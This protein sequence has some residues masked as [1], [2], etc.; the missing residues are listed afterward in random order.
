MRIKSA[1]AQTPPVGG[2][3]GG[4]PVVKVPDHGMSSSSVSL[5][6]HRV[7]ERCKLNLSELKRSPVGVVVRRVGCQ[8]RYRPRHLTMVQH[9]EVR[10]QKPSCS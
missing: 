9:Y 3:C 4:R 10:R 6:I 1:M 7:G 5:K 2:S 8:L